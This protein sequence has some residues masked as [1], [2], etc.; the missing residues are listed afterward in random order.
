MIKNS[1]FVIVNDKLIRRE[2]IYFSLDSRA[3]RYGDGFF[4]SMRAFGLEAPLFGYHYKRVE[5]AWEMMMTDLHLPDEK[6][7]TNAIARLLKSNKHFG[8][9]RLRLSFFRSGGGKYLP[10]TNK[11]D[12]YLESFASEEKEFVLNTRG[13]LIDVFEVMYKPVHPFLSIKSN[14]SQIYTLASL[15]AKNNNL[16]D[17]LIVNEKGMIVEATSSNVFIC[18]GNEIYT[19]P[20]TDGCVEGVMRAF[21][22]TELFPKMGLSFKEISFGKDLLHKADELF[23]TNAVQGIQWVVG[24]K[25]RRYFNK[26]SKTLSIVLNESLSA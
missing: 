4:E 15:W 19:P 7:F 24:Y 14:H 9:A 26:F 16:N 13:K 25:N 20:L 5:K 21:L 8:S 12:W 23:F 22:L 17:A 3:V 1:S 10:E 6:T 11:I 18:I 2:E